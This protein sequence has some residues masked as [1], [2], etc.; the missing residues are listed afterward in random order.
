M[1]I[2][3]W[4]EALAD[5]Q[6]GDLRKYALALSGKKSAALVSDNMEAGEMGLSSSKMLA[7]ATAAAKV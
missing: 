7:E 1:Q 5:N 4:A 2:A 6:V 3:T